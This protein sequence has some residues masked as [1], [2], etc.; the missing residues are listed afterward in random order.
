MATKRWKVR[1]H[2]THG[3]ETGK[4]PKLF[5]IGD[6]IVLDEE[7]AARIPWAVV[8]D[9]EAADDEKAPAAEKAKKAEKAEKPSK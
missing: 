7:A 3:A 8:L 9:E 5:D 4:P 6:T 2:V 1:S